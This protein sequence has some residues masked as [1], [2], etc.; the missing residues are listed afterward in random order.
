MSSPS[1]DWVEDPVTRPLSTASTYPVLQVYGLHGYRFYLIHGTA[2]VCLS[3]GVTCSACTFTYLT[4]PCRG[5][6]YKRSIG[7][8]AVEQDICLLV[9]VLVD[10]S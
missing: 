4:Y 9:T 6:F 7:R 3:I 8:L 10:A 1:D 5:D 2:L